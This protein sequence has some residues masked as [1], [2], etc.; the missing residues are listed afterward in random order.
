MIGKETE[1]TG[2]GKEKKKM[3]GVEGAIVTMTRKEVMT[4]KRSERDQENGPRSGEVGARWKKKNIKKT[5]MTGGTGMTKK[6]PKKRKNTVEAEAEKGSIEVGV[7]VGMQGNGVE[8]GARR[9]PVSTRAKARRSQINEVGVAVKEELT[10][11]K[12]ENGSGAPAKIN[13]ESVA[14]AKNVPTNGIT[15]IARTSLTNTISGGAKAQN[16]RAKKKH[17]KTKTRLC[18]HAL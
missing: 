4:E 14:A 8:A 16:Q 10:V 12:K 1:G 2:I 3:R 15:V 5:K 7:E 11:L 13:L 9:N 18:E 6:I 17:K